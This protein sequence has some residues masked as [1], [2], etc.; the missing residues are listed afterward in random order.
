MSGLITSPVV[1]TDQDLLEQSER[2][3]N[4]EADTALKV[5]QT[6]YGRVNVAV[7]VVGVTVT[8]LSILAST[9]QFIYSQRHSAPQKTYIFLSSEPRTVL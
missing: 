4:L 3:K 6:R 9:A 2:I 7:A 5:Q 8:A 1:P